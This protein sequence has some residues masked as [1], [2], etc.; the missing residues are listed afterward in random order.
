MP[1]V[2][3]DTVE[4]LFEYLDGTEHA[5]EKIKLVE[6][7]PPTLPNEPEPGFAEVLVVVNLDDSAI[8]DYD[9][10]DKF[11]LEIYADDRQ[12]AK[13]VAESIN[14]LVCLAEGWETPSALIDTAEHRSGPA[15]TP[16]PSE[17]VRRFDL[18]FWLTVR[19][20]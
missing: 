8:G 17:H 11:L 1:L 20:I 2:W 12:V 10:V 19:P 6:E 7:K 13:E 5:G 4:A 18:R 16:H 3:P 14:S 9:R 15:F